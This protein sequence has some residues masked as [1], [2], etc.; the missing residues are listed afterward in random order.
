MRNR[1]LAI[2][3]SA[4]GSTCDGMAKR[5]H[6]RMKRRRYGGAHE[7]GRGR[8]FRLRLIIRNLLRAG[9]VGRLGLGRAVTRVKKQYLGLVN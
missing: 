7:P 8:T 4:S 5:V 6:A 3:D 9:L 2:Q 1:R